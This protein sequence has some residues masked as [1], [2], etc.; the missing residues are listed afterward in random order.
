MKVLGIHSLTHD[1]GTALCV[2]G[3]IKYAVEEE[4]LSQIK[5]HPGIE[6]EG[7]PPLK[8]LNW[9]LNQEGL[10][11]DKVDKIVHV[12]WPGDEFMRLDLIRGRYREFAKELDPKGKKTTFVSHHKAHAASAYYASGFSDALVLSID[13]A[14]DWISSS[15]YVGKEEEL[16]KIDEYFIDQSLGFMYSRASKLLGLGQF[17]FSEGKL[18]ALAAYG[19]PIR[20][21]PPIVLIEGD[22]YKLA[23]GYYEVFKEFKCTEE[24]L[25]QRHKDFA[26]TVQK[27]LEDT[28]IHI[29][30]VAH[31]KYGKRNLALG[32]G[33]ALNCKMNGKLKL[34]P[35]V[36]K[37]FV[38]PAAND[39]GLCVGAA[40]IGAIEGGDTVE[41]MKSVY[42]GPDILESEVEGYVK[43]NRLV[44]HRVEKPYDIA[45]HL[46][47][48]GQTVGWVQGR[49]EFGPRALGHR[50]LL[51]DPRDISMRD[52]LNLI[53]KRE[54]WRP[55]AP[56]IIKSDKKYFVLNQGTEFMTNAVMMN[57]LAA[58][59]IPGAIHVDSTA[60]VQ[61]MNDESDM[62]YKLIKSFEGRTG[63]PAV[64]NTSLNRKGEPLCAAVEESIRFFYTT[65]TDNLFIGPWWFKKR[66]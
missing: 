9:I 37:M 34:L 50:S 65:P 52:K 27:T 33:V 11:L 15:L 59:E 6:V 7:Y 48:Q 46:I 26:A 54:L 32:G 51:G 47:E 44:S 24:N 12:G 20:S 29:L 45:A 22:R 43:Q 55:I 17:G 28:V 63:I 10:S 19:Q 39:G 23:E 25:T 4:R 13:G 49:L 41:C 8:S 35:W 40:Y 58:Q 64:L 14:G 2:D 31:E 53:K 60:R 61:V 21:F 66:S 1:L 38:Q 62:F 5:H 57:K 16:K 36:E 18:T 42:L 3:N 56:S 30:N